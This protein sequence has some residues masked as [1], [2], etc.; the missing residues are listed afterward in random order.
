MNEIMEVGDRF[1]VDLYASHVSPGYSSKRT[2]LV[3]KVPV[4]TK[5]EVKKRIK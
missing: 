2:N 4:V 3:Y 1:D 5:G